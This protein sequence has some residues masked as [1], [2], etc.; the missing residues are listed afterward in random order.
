MQKITTIIQHIKFSGNDP[1]RLFHGRGRLHA[2]LEAVNVD[3]LCPVLLITLYDEIEG[4][5]LDDLIKALVDVSPAEMQSIVV[6]RRYLKPAV[7]ETLYGEDVARFSIS[8]QG[9]LYQLD[10]NAGMHSGLFLDMAEARQRVR[11][12]A[13]GK[14]VLNLFSYTCAFSVAA[15]AGGAESVVNMDLSRPSLNRGRESHR[16]NHHD[17]SRVVFHGHDIFKSWGKLKR[18]GPFDLVIVDPPSFQKGSFELAKDYPRV[19]RQL[20]AL[21]AEGGTVLAC[22]NDPDKT[23][24]YLKGLFAEHCPELEFKERLANPK[25]FTD[26]DEQ[27]SLK[28]LYFQRGT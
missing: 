2:D 5:W 6:Q 10:F 27:R 23:P 12:Q 17:M 1:Q 8:E 7:F 19:A 13:M 28:V 20:P 18:L 15:L 24:E 14:K 21:L 16:L 11:A 22:L 9:V 25:A 26:K 3:W 4:D